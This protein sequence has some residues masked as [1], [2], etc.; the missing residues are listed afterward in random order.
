MEYLLEKH[1][2]SF[3]DIRKLCFQCHGLG[4]CSSIIFS[5]STYSD[6][7]EQSKSALHSLLSTS[8]LHLAISIRINL[9]Q[10]TID[11]CVIPLDSM[12]ADYYENEKLIYQETSIKD[13]CDKIIHADKVIKPIFPDRPLEPD[14][15]ITIQLRGTNRKVGW[16][17][18][19][20][21]ER[22][23]ELILKTLDRIENKE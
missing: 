4:L 19:L 14:E 15:Y 13:V 20:C 1:K 16:T 17:L 3:D 23:A 2:Q 12:A 10:D 11:N 8:L 9:Y 7:S 21:I 5:G 18:N 6:P 22:F